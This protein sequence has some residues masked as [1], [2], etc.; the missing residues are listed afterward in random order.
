MPQRLYAINS[1]LNVKKTIT[2]NTQ[3]IKLSSRR[4]LYEYVFRGGV[5]YKF[6]K[7]CFPFA[8]F[9]DWVP[10]HCVALKH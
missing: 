10:T 5:N 9:N 4:E 8:Q 3:R 7:T 6:T 1:G 2:E